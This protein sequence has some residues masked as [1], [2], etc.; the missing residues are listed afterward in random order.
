MQELNTPTAYRYIVYIN[1][2]FFLERFSVVNAEKLTHSVYAQ[3]KLYKNEFIQT[4]YY[5]YIFI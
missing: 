4:I 1:V 2:C 5:M 3:V